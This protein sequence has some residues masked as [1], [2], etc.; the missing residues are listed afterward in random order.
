MV[1]RFALRLS[2]SLF[3][4]PRN[5]WHLLDYSQLK[6][7]W[8]I[9]ERG[10]IIHRRKFCERLFCDSVLKKQYK[11]PNEL[12]LKGTYK[13]MNLWKLKGVESSEKCPYSELFWSVFSRIRTEYIQSECG[14][15][16]SRRNSNTGTFHAVTHQVNWSVVYTLFSK[17]NWKNWHSYVQKQ[18]PEVFCEKSIP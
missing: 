4:L 15:M 18:S 7:W 2:C 3:Y 14:K 5:F 16:Q 10:D 1:I 9:K 13:R 12:Y 11:H 17:R 8:N 6:Y